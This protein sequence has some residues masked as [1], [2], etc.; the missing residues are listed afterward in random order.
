MEIEVLIRGDAC[1]DE[2]GGKP[3]GNRTVQISRHVAVLSPLGQ[4]AEKAASSLAH[5]LRCIHV[6]PILPGDVNGGNLPGRGKLAHAV[7]EGVPSL[8]LRLLERI[9]QNPRA[10]EHAGVPR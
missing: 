5:S 3:R 2:P 6:D 7:R 9:E 1:R 8:S 4:A 10:Q